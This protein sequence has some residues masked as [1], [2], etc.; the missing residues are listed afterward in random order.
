MVYQKNDYPELRQLVSDDL[1]SPDEGSKAAFHA[2][3]GDSENEFSHASALALGKWTEFFDS[4][5]HDD[6]RGVTVSAITFTAFN[7]NI[8][9]FKLFMSGYTV[10]SGSL[11]RRVLEGI[12]LSL[13]CSAKSLTVLDRFLDNRYS[14][15]N[16]VGDLVKHSRAVQV[17]AGAVQ[18]TQNAYKFYHKYA[19]LSKL[20]IAAGTNFAHGGIPNVGA[21][22]DP[23]KL[24]EYKKEVKGRVS[25]A[26]VLPN[27]VERIM[28]N[29]RDW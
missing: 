7:H 21:F 1:R 17:N 25:L 19:H 20:T 10:A 3:F 6:K 23:A 18:T 9:S 29:V 15:N 28:L 2:E 11:F 12:S 16:A 24:P 22:F 8:S 26:R 4:I 5:G 13:L 27:I 14:S